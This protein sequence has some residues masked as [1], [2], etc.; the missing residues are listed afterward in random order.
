[1]RDNSILKIRV[2]QIGQLTAAKRRKNKAYGA[3]GCYETFCRMR[4]V[5]QN[6]LQ[7]RSGGMGKPGTAVPGRRKWNNPSPL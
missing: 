4:T 7:P 5:E 6:K 3:R 2:E 1:V